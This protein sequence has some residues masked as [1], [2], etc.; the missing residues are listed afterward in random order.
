MAEI[1]PFSMDILVYAFEILEH[2]NLVK[3]YIF[4]KFRR[5]SFKIHELFREPAV[6]LILI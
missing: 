4:C 2:L 3:C 1:P 6:E 5:I